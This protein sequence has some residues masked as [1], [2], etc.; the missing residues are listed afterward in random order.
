ML[1]KAFR[2]IQQYLVAAIMEKEMKNL[3]LHEKHKSL[4]ANFT[5]FHGWMLPSD[6]GDMRNEYDAV[7][8]AVGIADLSHRG[9]LKLSGKHHLKFLQG[10]LTNNVEN[11]EPGTGMHAALLTV[12]GRMVSDMKVYKFE[13]SILF[14]LE[15]GV[16]IKV[17][18]L[19][20]KYRLSYK[21]DIEDLSDTQ[22]L[23]SLNGPNAMSLVFKV[24]DLPP[25]EMNEYDHFNAELGGH[26]VTVAKVSR[27][28]FDGYDI[29]APSGASESIWDLFLSEG[30]ELGI[31]PV[32]QNAMNVLRIEAGI[33]EYGTD[34]D[35]SNI[36]I[37]AGIWDALDFEKGCYVGQEV[38]ARIKWRGHVNWHL[39][40]IVLDGNTIPAPGDEIYSGERK[41]GRITSG[42]FSPG[43]NKPIALGY[44]RRE[45]KEPGTK[46]TVNSDGDTVSEASISDTPFDI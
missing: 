7:R 3:T 6:Y 41:I 11:L 34:M 22:S 18:E 13:D 29:Y 30:Q 12:K 36:P 31:L 10:M 4:G 37:E 23:F 46:V 26:E 45:F 27:T 38:V 8:S 20:T 17:G 43:L 19:L 25:R 15:P 33:P 39:L 21:A 40:G 1:G 2:L 32:G 44:I 16:N 35:E 14:D 5:Q 28:K 9:K 42:V 24:L